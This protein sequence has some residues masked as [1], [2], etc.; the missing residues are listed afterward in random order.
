MN[1]F[2]AMQRRSKSKDIDSNHLPV[3]NDFVDVACGGKTDTVCIEAISRV[4]FEASGPSTVAVGSLALFNYGNR[5]GRYRFR[6]TCTKLD[7]KHAHFALPSEITVIET[8]DEKRGGF[9][10]KKLLSITWR[11]AP[12]GVGNGPFVSGNLLDLSAEGACLDVGREVRK[13]TQVE[14]RFDQIVADGKP[15]VAI[16]QLM[17]PSTRNGAGVIVSGLQFQGLGYTGQNA[18]S[19]FIV[20]HEKQ[21]KVRNIAR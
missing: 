7:G 13:G 1:L 10:L 15:L 21:D 9:R 12:D 4:D 16:A 14:I 19:E 6:T 11:Y 3:V 2:Q 5:T 18:I 20:T 8:F 17:R